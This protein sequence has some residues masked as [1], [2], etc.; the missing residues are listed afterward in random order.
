MAGCVLQFD[1]EVSVYFRHCV[2][3][4]FLDIATVDIYD[5]QE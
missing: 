5:A 1:Y 4:E 3:G 2:H